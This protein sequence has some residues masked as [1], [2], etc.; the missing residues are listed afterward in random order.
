MTERFG[1]QDHDPQITQ[2]ALQNPTNPGQFSN[3]SSDQPYGPHGGFT[4]I[5]FDPAFVER[6]TR[7]NMR[8]AVILALLFGPLG[9]FYTSRKA[10]YIALAATLLL[11]L[12]QA[13]SLLDLGI[14]FGP[15]W[16]LARLVAIGWNI[17]AMRIYQAAAKGGQA[18]GGD[19]AL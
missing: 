10:A 18:S 6:M 15:S 14:F 2:H 7:R 12:L 5:N 3:I 4:A 9:M 1:I 19:K 16:D 17:H 8:T 13:G 11:S